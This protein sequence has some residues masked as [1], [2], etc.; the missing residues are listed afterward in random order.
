MFL[1]LIGSA[2]IIITSGFLG[3][4]LSKE[5]GRRPRE[6][7]ELQNLLQM[8][9][10]EISF[11]SNT[12]ADAFNKLSDYSTSS[13][14]NFFKQTSLNL[15]K[16]KCCS[17]AEAW[18]AAVKEN[19]EK[20]SLNKEDKEV[21][22]SFGKILGAS[23]IEGQIK[24]IRLTCTQLKMQEEKAEENKKKNEGMYRNLGLLG[25]LALVIIIV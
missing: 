19:F 6:L 8:F 18:E 11:L 14:R 24:N 12:I 2:L 17:A 22:I 21:L 15:I 16:G 23:D 4:F 9:E 3:L 5:C 13:T 20:T 7:R 10:N 1:K 25:G